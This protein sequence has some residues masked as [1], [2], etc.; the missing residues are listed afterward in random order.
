MAET[1]TYITK[2]TCSRSI[3]VRISDNLVESVEFKGGCPGNLIGINEL[4]KGMDVNDV[5]ER[6]EGVKCGS[7]DTSCPDQLSKALR[8]YLENL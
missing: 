8:K 4:V 3:D 7:K 6:L 1:L 2:G 5:V